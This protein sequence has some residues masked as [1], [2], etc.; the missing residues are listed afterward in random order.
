M[1]D[2][3]RCNLIKPLSLN[4]SPPHWRACWSPSWWGQWAVPVQQKN[5]RARRRFPP[6]QW[7]GWSRDRWAAFLCRCACL[8]ACSGQPPVDTKYE[9]TWNDG[10]KQRINFDAW[11]IGQSISFCASFQIN[12]GSRLQ[13]AKVCDPSCDPCVRVT[14]G[15][16]LVSYDLH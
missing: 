15:I 14:S 11:L 2:W 8:W 3:S 6:W 9:G 12:T 7:G 4:H 16:K 13:L 10:R 5:P 1:W